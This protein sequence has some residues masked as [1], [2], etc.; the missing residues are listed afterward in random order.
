VIAI[1]CSALQ[2]YAPQGKGA[3]IRVGDRTST[4]HSGLTYFITRLAEDLAKADK[5]FAYQRA[6]MPGG[7]C[8][9]TVYDVYGFTAASICV[10]LGNYHNMDREKKRIGPEYVDV[11]DWNSMVSLFVQLA[12]KSHEFESG[13]PLLKKRLEKR[14]NALR[15]H[16]VSKSR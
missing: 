6:L 11:N 3:V 2:P 7:T 1:E 5:T 13:M 8:E 9:A 12:K 4:F 14:F 10:A 16:L 15:R